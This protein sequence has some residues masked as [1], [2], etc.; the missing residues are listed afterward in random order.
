MKMG[1]HLICHTKGTEALVGQPALEAIPLGHPALLIM[2]RF[3][4]S[5]VPIHVLKGFVY[6][7]NE[8]FEEKN[9]L[10]K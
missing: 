4:I 1:C 2:K 7:K 9:V 8:A 3:S 5:N 10:L 6:S